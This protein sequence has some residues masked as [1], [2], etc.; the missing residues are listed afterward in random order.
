M[1]LSEP[2]RLML[3]IESAIT[4]E[5]V[6]SRGYTT[7]KTPRDVRA[8]GFFGAQARTPALVLPLHAVSGE[9]SRYQLR[10]DRPRMT[11]AGREIKYE[12]QT[13]QRM[14]L[15][16]H[17]SQ[18]GKLGNPDV[19]LWITEGI[20]KADALSSRDV[21][22]VALMGVWNWRGRNTYD[23]L[24][25]LPDWEHV[26]LNGRD[27][28]IVFD[29]DVSKKVEV[30]SALRRLYL[31][32]E[33]RKAHPR[34][35]HL[36]ERPDKVGVDDALAEGLSL[37]DLI[38]MSTAGVPE[39]PARK[40]VD[41]LCDYLKEV[42][43]VID[44]A[45]DIWC[46]VSK[47]AY[48]ETYSVPERA[49]K[50]NL[51]RAWLMRRYLGD[52]GQV[53]QP[54]EIGRAMDMLH[55]EGVT[56]PDVPQ[57]SVYFRIGYL[58]NE[59]IYIDLGSRNWNCIEIDADGWRIRSDAPVLFRRHNAMLPLPEPDKEGSMAALREVLPMAA[60]SPEEVL[61]WGWLLGTLMPGGPYPHLCLHGEAGSAKSY[62]TRTLR[63][64]IDPSRSPL[65]SLPKDEEALAYIAKDSAIVTVENVSMITPEQSD[66]FCRLATGL[67]FKA[68]KL[69][70]N[71][72][73]R[74][75]YVR[76]PVILNGINE[77]VSSGD[78]RD[79]SIIVMLHRLSQW[80]SENEMDAVFESL[81][82][83]ILGGL[84]SAAACALKNLPAQ[85]KLGNVRMADFARWA[86]A[87]SQGIGWEPDTYL[88]AYESMQREAI[89]H[90]VES[91]PVGTCLMTYLAKKEG[92]TDEMELTGLYAA[93]R[94]IQTGYGE[95]SL[96][97]NWPSD[98][99]RFGRI[100]RRLTPAFRK[101][102]WEI[103][104]RRK[105]KGRCIQILPVRSRIH[106]LAVSEHAGTMPKEK[107]LTDGQ[108]VV[109]VDRCSYET[110][111]ND[112][113][114]MPET[115]ENNTN[116][117]NNALNALNSI[118]IDKELEL[119]GGKRPEK[120][121]KETIGSDIKSIKSTENDKSNEDKGLGNV[122]NVVNQEHVN[123]TP[124]VKSIGQS[125]TPAQ[126]GIVPTRCPKCGS[127]R[128]T[129][130]GTSGFTCIE[131]PYSSGE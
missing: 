128:M 85:P 93:L 109:N 62:T 21:C 3:E 126:A 15:D 92:G 66:W 110:P 42:D 131:C 71:D 13:G 58:G 50:G 105:A 26:A 122:V 114:D 111:L 79:R 55:A 96:P 94:N 16:C 57:Q 5:T 89:E 75:I 40:Q 84:C 48:R 120:T 17:P 72:A 104:T 8:F 9:Q 6:A 33:Y 117:K 97:K 49:E 60:E 11:K 124:D 70:S 29:N 27:I 30:L 83:K 90:E 100:I 7:V 116:T 115:I 19:P 73:I 74:T 53:P 127:S 51:L 77:V 20:K 91:S 112:I 99:I 34:I 121:I 82:P 35:V 67:G 39:L 119:R 47:G 61:V 95:D 81:H 118:G 69:Y 4:S 107:T 125:D 37:D 108:H 87:A 24:T 46:L 129:R 2:H 56:D 12:H 25:V 28:F 80:A 78:L 14:L 1:P 113:N 43:L 68:R 22:C 36:P 10:P 86:S 65:D 18:A 98:M 52:H 64:I 54:S 32:L 59:K 38:G 41:I 76:R 123:D 101:L 103:I 31:W 130:R 45:Q 63:Q 23:G 102:G 106:G 88:A 44:D